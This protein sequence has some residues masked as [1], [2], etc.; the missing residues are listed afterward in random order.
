M[1]VCACTR[2]GTHIHS[3]TL[4]HAHTDQWV[5]LIAF[6]QQK[7]FHERTSVLRYTYIDRLVDIELFRLFLTCVFCLFVRR[8]L[9]LCHA[10]SVN[11]ESV[12]RANRCTTIWPF[13]MLVANNN[14]SHIVAANY[15]SPCGNSDIILC[16]FFYRNSWREWFFY[17]PK[18]VWY[19]ATVRCGEWR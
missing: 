6:P 19:S 4:R 8:V 11:I 16:V 12:H 17:W 15:A 10:F 1:R 2:P 5:V 13:L 3:R 18:Q 14:T 7:W 9:E